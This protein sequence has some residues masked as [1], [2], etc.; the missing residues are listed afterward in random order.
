MWMF[1]APVTY[2]CTCSAPPVSEA[3]AQADVVFRGTIIALR[4]SMKPALPFL[5]HDTQKIAV[6]QISRVWKGDVRTIFEMPAIE[7]TSACWGFRPDQLKIGNDL[8]VY[9]YGWPEEPDGGFFSTTICSRTCSQTSLK[10]STSLVLD[11][12]HAARSISFG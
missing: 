3:R 12:N 1:P 7:E 5:G 10:I 6:F 9:A 8:L 4:P 11:M 2:A